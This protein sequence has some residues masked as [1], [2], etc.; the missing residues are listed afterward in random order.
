MPNDKD[1]EVVF[2]IV[3]PIGHLKSFPSGWTKELNIV[4]WNDGDAKFDIRDWDMEHKHMTRG[5]TL[6]SDEM[7][8]LLG[9]M[10]NR[11]TDLQ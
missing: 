11:T 5:V 4:R 3:E 9:L 2:E 1:R 8:A 6:R 10:K 7:D